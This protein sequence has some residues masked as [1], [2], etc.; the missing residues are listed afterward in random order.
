MTGNTIDR[1]AR[2]RDAVIADLEDAMLTGRLRPGDRLPSERQLAAQNHVSRPVIREGLRGLAAKGLIEV[3]PGKGTFV[4]RA[5]TSHDAAR[6]EVQ[7]RRRGA[8]VRDVT[9]ARLMLECEAAGL[10][11]QRADRDDV[12]A[13]ERAL[14][15]LERAETRIDHIRRDLAFHMA[16]AS[17]TH[18][19]VIRTMFVA[20]SRLS[21]EIMVRSVE[22]SEMRGTSDHYHGL[23]VEA[24][25]ARDPGAAR[26]AIYAHLA[27]AQEA[28]GPEYEERLDLAALRG[29]RTLGYGDIESFMEAVLGQDRRPW[30]DEPDA[31]GEADPAGRR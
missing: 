9:E 29:L 5:D 3:L 10:A 14:L 21:A 28:Y 20:I 27:V 11:A 8:T 7:F 1:R 4:L 25:R 18:N 30:L 22:D 19:P 26:K 17:A 6:L 23:A 24:I 31:D 12:L 13:L 2:S 15:A 16:I